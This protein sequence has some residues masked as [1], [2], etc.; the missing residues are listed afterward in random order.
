MFPVSGYPALLNSVCYIGV[1]LALA[2]SEHFRATGRT[3]A[4]GRRLPILHGY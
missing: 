1:E 2:D 4:L 3:D